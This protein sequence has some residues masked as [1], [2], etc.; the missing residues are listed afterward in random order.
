[1]TAPSMAPATTPKPK[2]SKAEIIG[3]VRNFAY[4]YYLSILLVAFGVYD[5][6]NGRTVIAVIY[7]G[8]GVLAAIVIGAFH[9]NHRR[10]WAA[11]TALLAATNQKFIDAGYARYT[12]P[13]L[14]DDMYTV[15]DGL[16][17]LDQDQHS[18]SV[19]PSTTDAQN[20]AKQALWTGANPP[21]N[22]GAKLTVLSPGNQ[23]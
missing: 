14:H 2:K 23:S 8:L 12:H 13:F 18:V 16:V 5:W 21:R 20:L 3:G 9:Y 7:G 1:M 19:R 11:S 22:R 15:G 17:I 10:N 4:N 6:A